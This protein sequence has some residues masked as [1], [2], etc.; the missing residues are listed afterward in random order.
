MG[1][2]PCVQRRVGFYSSKC[3]VS[4]VR[5]NCNGVMFSNF[6]LHP[7]TLESSSFSRSSAAEDKARQALGKRQALG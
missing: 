4:F 7:R 1:C 2:R 3:S 6:K 5:C